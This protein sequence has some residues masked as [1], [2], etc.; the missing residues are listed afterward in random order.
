M[1]ITGKAQG[2]ITVEWKSKDTQLDASIK[3][4]T[5]AQ[6]ETKDRAD[7]VSAAISRQ[8]E[9][10]GAVNKSY[11][12]M[13]TAAGD[14]LAVVRGIGN[15]LQ[16][17][18]REQSLT[19]QVRAILGASGHMEELRRGIRDTVKEADLAGAALSLETIN[20]TAKQAADIGLG[21]LVL[22]ERKGIESTQ[23]LQQ[24]VQKLA[25]GETGSFKELGIHAKT[26]AGVIEELGKIGKK[27]APEV[28]KSLNVSLQRASKNLDDIKR[29]FA[30]AGAGVLNFV[31]D[32]Q[33]GLSDKEAFKPLREEYQRIIG[34][35]DEDIE[36]A[37]AKAVDAV[38]AV[39][40]TVSDALRTWNIH[41]TLVVPLTSGFNSIASA[42]LGAGVAISSM[43]RALREAAAD[44]GKLLGRAAFDVRGPGMARDQFE[45]GHAKF[46]DKLDAAYDARRRGGGAGASER[47]AWA[48]WA[49]EQAALGAKAA[50]EIARAFYAGM[51]DAASFNL[52][53][54]KPL[55]E[56]GIQGGRPN[57]AGGEQDP[58]NFTSPIQDRMTAIQGL[59]DQMS[60]GRDAASG[61]AGAFEDM[62]A[63]VGDASGSKKAL[64]VMRGFKAA[65]LAILAVE[66]AFMGGLE[67]ARGL[68][69]LSPYSGDIPWVHFAAS[70]AFFAQAAGKGAAIAA[71]Y[72]G[73]GGGGKGSTRGQ[74]YQAPPDMTRR[75]RSDE[76]K[77][78]T[79]NIMGPAMDSP[80]FRRV[81]TD[82]VRR[83]HREGYTTD[84]SGMV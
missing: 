51:R 54:N 40:G 4:L 43:G 27:A 84:P 77:S 58:K 42:A 68:A 5:A 10:I 50:A 55:P 19:N 39:F 35:S 72:S 16:D 79:V 82:A 18:G 46:Y 32:L 53:S 78:I 83:G 67:F 24:I 30:E 25:S 7:A 80:A 36:V 13:R 8:K 44:T 47:K 45:I 15:A 12:S 71:L 6:R 26:V 38:K 64:A 65:S 33:N 63:A 81:V 69:A 23:M 17:V 9:I 28:D 60:K 73:G 1:G 61:F 14:V 41:E 75:N 62:W 74:G 59:Q 11:M 22:A 66:A 70:A 3:K 76:A 37:K 52:P 57:W 34:P 2:D 31:V 29:G 21:T 20:V 48:K 49:H 56:Y